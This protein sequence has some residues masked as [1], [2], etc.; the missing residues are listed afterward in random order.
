MS[1]LKTLNCLNWS[2]FAVFCVP[3][4]SIQVVFKYINAQNQQG[5]KLGIRAG[6]NIYI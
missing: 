6:N 3:L 2:H 5:D 1:P 4:F